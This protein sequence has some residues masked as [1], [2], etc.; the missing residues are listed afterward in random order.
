MARVN[1]QLPTISN[2]EPGGSAVL[3]CPLGRTYDLTRFKFESADVAFNAL[4]DAQQR[5]MFTNIGVEINGT[6]HVPLPS[7]VVLQA[8]NSYYGRADA[9]GYFTLHFNRAELHDL[10]QQRQFGLGT[11]GL[12][13][14]AITFDI[15][16]AAPADLTI[17][18][19]ARQREGMDPGAIIKTR[20]FHFGAATAGPL[21]IDNILKGSPIMAM[22]IYK[23]GDDVDKVNVDLN[24]FA[25]VKNATKDD[26]ANEQADYG[27]TAQTGYTHVDF[28]LEGDYTQAL[29]TKR[30]T[31][32]HPADDFRQLLT[33]GTAG[34][35]WVLVEYIDR[36]VN[37]V[38]G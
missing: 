35:G 11:V 36:A 27:R 22:H 20:L 15:D 24:D 31:P 19:R 13:T 3:K 5:A 38:L 1:A 2:V 4:T 18:A 34:S 21:E 10:I 25:W 32:E 17:T 23:A 29:A 28:C 33:L 6:N 30:A 9:S 16:A 37:G 8:V 26:L 7:A 12:E 14:L